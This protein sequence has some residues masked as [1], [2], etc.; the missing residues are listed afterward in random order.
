MASLAP[1]PE[2]IITMTRKITVI[3]PSTTVGYF[4]SALLPLQC[5]GVMKSDGVYTAVKYCMK[6]MT[7]A[8][9]DAL[10]F[11]CQTLSRP[12]R[13]TA[14]PKQ[15][16]QVGFQYFVQILLSKAEQSFS[17]IYIFCK[18]LR[19]SYSKCNIS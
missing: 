2:Q 1:I 12:F 10:I 3:Y 11:R 6:V 9:S 18:S 7:N 15:L 16:Q 19:V 4:H 14:L 17:H 8:C 13:T 5:I